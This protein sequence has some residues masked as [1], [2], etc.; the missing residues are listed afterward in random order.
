MLNRLLLV[1]RSVSLKLKV[2][3]FTM[4]EAGFCCGPTCSQ[5]LQNANLMRSVVTSIIVENRDDRLNLD[6]FT[7]KNPGWIICI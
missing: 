7:T 6:Y 4:A 5:L 3:Q 2:L 1:S